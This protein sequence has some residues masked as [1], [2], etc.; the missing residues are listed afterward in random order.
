MTTGAGEP[1]G[2]EIALFTGLMALVGVGMLLAL[3]FVPEWRTNHTY[4]EGRCLVLDKRL[5][6]HPPTGKAV[7]STYRPEFFIRYRVAGR[8][9]RVWAYKAVKVSS[10]LRWPKEQ[11]L[12]GFTVGQ[13]Y[14]CWY[15]PAEPT[16][17]V[18]DRGYSW[19][20]YF[21]LAALLVLGFFTVRGFVRNLRSPR[22]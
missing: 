11:V 18:V 20:S 2:D 15:D 14:P 13:E 21:L 1:R 9:Y 17:V 16:K 4:V 7:N 6:E 22:Q 8:D 10:A 3:D 19:F 5:G 12:D